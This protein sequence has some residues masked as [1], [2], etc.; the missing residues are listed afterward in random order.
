MALDAAQT[1]HQTLL[2]LERS[3]AEPEQQLDEAARILNVDPAGLAAYISPRE[4]D[5]QATDRLIAPREDWVLRW[6]LKRTGAGDKV[7]LFVL[8]TL[9]DSSTNN[10]HSYRSSSKTWQVFA[11][12]VPFI[13]PKSAARTFTEYGLLE[14]LEA[15]LGTL[16][17]KLALEQ[18]SGDASPKSSH[19]H[20][21]FSRKRKRGSFDDNL[22]T[23]R[24]SKITASSAC[25]AILHG[26][27]EC[28]QLAQHA[29]SDEVGAQH[30]RAALQANSDVTSKIL[31]YLLEYANS[32]SL[33]SRSLAERANDAHITLRTISEILCLWDFRTADGAENEG[34]SSDR[35][36]ADF[37]LVPALSLLESLRTS[38]Q[39]AHDCHGLKLR[40]QQMIVLHVLYPARTSFL[41]LSSSQKTSLNAVPGIDNREV[42]AT[43]LGS[44]LHGEHPEVQQ[45]PSITRL[46][47]SLLDL[48]TKASPLKAARARQEELPWL[49]AL[50]AVLCEI[51]GTPVT[52]IEPKPNT[53]ESTV[54]LEDCLQI[55]LNNNVALPLPFLSL[56]ASTYTG[57]LSSS[58]ST[59]RWELVSRLIKLDVNVFLPNS[60]IEVSQKL[61]EALLAALS[62]NFAPDGN[63]LQSIQRQ[64]VISL[65]K[66]F[67]EARDTH[68]LF[69]FLRQQISASKETQNLDEDGKT[70]VWD[71]EE[72]LDA[73][74]SICNTSISP[75]TVGRELA[76][77]QHD[78]KENTGEQSHVLHVYASAAVFNAILAADARLFA[79]YHDALRSLIPQIVINLPSSRQAVLRKTFY[80]LLWHTTSIL[81][82][83]GKSFWSAPL[84]QSAAIGLK[85]IQSTLKQPAVDDQN[86]STEG[87]E[88]FRLLLS[89]GR[90]G[91]PL[92]SCERA[93][94]LLNNSLLQWSANAK[95]HVTD[96][97]NGGS[98]SSDTGD[99][100][101]LVYLASTLLYP[102]VLGLV[103]Q[104][105]LLLF[106]TLLQCAEQD[107]EKMSPSD[108]ATMPLLNILLAFTSDPRVVS[109]K[110]LIGQMYEA[111]TAKCESQS[112]LHNLDLQVLLNLPSSALSRSRKAFLCD[113]IVKNS[114]RTPSAL[115]GKLALLVDLVEGSDGSASILKSAKSFFDFAVQCSELV[116]TA[117]ETNVLE[118]FR[119]F[120]ETVWQRMLL[121]AGTA[122]F[123]NYISEFG[124]IMSAFLRRAERKQ[125]EVRSTFASPTPLA[126]SLRHFA[127]LLCRGATSF[128]KARSTDDKTKLIKSWTSLLAGDLAVL[129]KDLTITGSGGRSLYVRWILDALISL[130][131]INISLPSF[132]PKTLSKLE[133]VLTTFASTPPVRDSILHRLQSLRYSMGLQDDGSVAE[134]I[135]ERQ[136]PS[137]ISSFTSSPSPNTLSRLS[138]E[139][140]LRDMKLLLTS[141]NE[142]A[143]ILLLQQ[144]EEDCRR[145]PH[146]A[147]LFLTIIAAAQSIRLTDRDSR[148]VQTLRRILILLQDSLPKTSD[149]GL[150]SIMCDCNTYLITIHPI[151]VNSFSF[152]NTLKAITLT[153]SSSGPSF[154]STESDYT[155]SAIYPRL[156]TMA[157]HLLS[158]HRK[159]LRG[160]HHLL[161]QNLTSLL[162]CLFNPHN[163]RYTSTTHSNPLLALP[164]WALTSP[165]KPKMATSYACL[166]TTLA[167]PTVSSIPHKNNS[168]SALNDIVARARHMEGTFLQH[169]VQTYCACRLHG[170]MESEVK[171]RLM[172][173]L[174]AVMESMGQEVMRACNGQMDAEM[175]GIFRGLYNEW[176][177]EGRWGGR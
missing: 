150:F 117:D 22:S 121:A 39:K 8:Q 26:L 175:R 102:D 133:E 68:T 3:K 124:S 114:E 152:E 56:I 53:H 149:V 74:T 158:R 172:P 60:G 79:D 89:L 84:D 165:P 76:K 164:S 25:G 32:Y 113:L 129:T 50:F 7:D 155:S 58:F 31:G 110:V 103:P 49:F 162:A 88:A 118:Q 54:C 163:V 23:P 91:L 67:V 19:R 47:P 86:A 143:V 96:L 75:P 126:V 17:K 6:L 131:K 95:S 61:L 134:E 16:L 80:R 93:L 72:I 85:S 44:T 135:K 36:F 69:D 166:L 167:D 151:L 29:T 15:T 145:Q 48:G 9:P 153:A 130:R 99:N 94:S 159:H 66:G 119:K 90:S 146:T 139:N 41:G 112:A 125:L 105:S 138:L 101:S 38:P 136:L 123:D 2:G 65:M 14:I 140:R 115:P 156:C 35:S 71:D 13:S 5:G 128:D 21:I 51:A 169:V 82:L 109:N 137:I 20:S 108:P 10:L 37:L 64:I 28:V 42:I 127:E 11:Y 52:G 40:L 92:Q 170:K 160:Q 122:K 157:T 168:S 73:L 154:P 177:S 27:R 98:D 174:Y 55:F 147:S 30:M 45:D 1:M 132:V 144:L 104:Q 57:L 97:S 70:I 4:K 18:R 148:G 106:Q 120:C 12:L 176:I 59:V 34:K 171:E 161:L 81:S 63:P 43:C 62:S 46:F 87:L 83:H 142:S 173:G 100:L 77:F 24:E 116:G 107:M 33:H 111:V 141:M 78:L